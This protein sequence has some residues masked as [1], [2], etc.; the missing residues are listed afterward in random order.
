MAG[1]Y[2]LSLVTIPRQVENNRPAKSLLCLCLRPEPW[3][4]LRNELPYSGIGSDVNEIRAAQFPEFIHGVK[5]NHKERVMVQRQLKKIIA[6]LQTVL[7]TLGAGLSALL[8]GGP[9]P[10]WPMRT[11]FWTRPSG[12]RPLAWG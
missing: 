1:F 12:V 9:A 8:V 6:I 10:A 3:I 7:Q 4:T 5:A 11:I 2:L